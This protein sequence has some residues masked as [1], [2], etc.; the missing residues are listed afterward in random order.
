MV[1]DNIQK[2]HRLHLIGANIM[3]AYVCTLFLEKYDLIQLGEAFR[4]PSA[5][6][7]SPNVGVFT[8][9]AHSVTVVGRYGRV[10]AVVVGPHV[11]TEFICRPHRVESRCVRESIHTHTHTDRERERESSHVHTRMP[12]GV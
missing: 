10:S 6:S 7:G 2:L 9:V 11:V 8:A 4:R 1:Y 12:G 5:G 3:M